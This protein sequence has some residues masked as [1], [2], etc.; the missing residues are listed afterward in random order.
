[1]AQLKLGKENEEL[2]RL[3]KRILRCR[4]CELFKDRTNAVPGEGNPHT[5][6]LI[7]G[8]A[9]GKSEDIQGRPFVGRAGK[10]LTEILT[11]AGIEREDVFITNIIKCRPPGN[12]VPKQKEVEACR[13][14]LH[15]QVELI[16]PALLVALGQSA[17]RTLTGIKGKMEDH[18]G[19]IYDYAGCR[20]LVTYHPAGVIYNRKLR[21]DMVRDIKSIKKIVKER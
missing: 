7:I 17:F 2:I 9:P 18:H 16:E 20:T 19:K 4:K 5:G 21:P 8:E 10:V 1:M 3:H 14:F 6:I 15:R 11:E 12:R 13:D